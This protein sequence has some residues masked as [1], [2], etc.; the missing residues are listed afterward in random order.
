MLDNNFT[1][2]SLSKAIKKPILNDWLFII[3]ARK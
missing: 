2:M 3:N 1:A